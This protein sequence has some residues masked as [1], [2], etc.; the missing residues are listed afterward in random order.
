MKLVRQ[1]FSQ[2]A[3][4]SAAAI[5]V[6]RFSFDVYFKSEPTIRVAWPVASSTIPLFD[7]ACRSAHSHSVFL[8]VLPKQSIVPPMRL[9]KT[10]LRPTADFAILSLHLMSGRNS[11]GVFCV[12]IPYSNPEIRCHTEE[13]GFSLSMVLK[14]G[15]NRATAGIFSS[16]NFSL[17]SY[18]EK[19]MDNQV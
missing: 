3:T 14:V 19:A 6:S 1:R 2:K 17:V 15:T 9:T 8:S 16:F 12:R 7:R 18:S 4:S 5:A 13:T 11:S 10:K